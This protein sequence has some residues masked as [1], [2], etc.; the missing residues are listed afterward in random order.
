MSFY[1]NNTNP[2]RPGPA[3]PNAM[4][5]ICERALIQ[6]TKV[7]D[8][9]LSQI[10]ETG[11]VLEL[12][13]L[14][15]ADPALPLTYIS[16]ENTP[17]QTATVSNLVIDRIETA[18][19]Y[20]NISLDVT[21]PVTVTYRD[22]NNVLGQGTSTITVTKNVVMFVP[23]PSATPINVTAQG[24]FNSR[25][26]TYTAENTFTVTGCLQIVIKVV[27]V[28]DILVPSYGY[29][30]L[31]PCQEGSTTDVCPGVFDTPIYPTATNN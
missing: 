5:G 30:V 2:F 15:P 26:G 11:I 28:V 12:T 10:T 25:I 16:A 24:L 22:A 7:F 27:G 23:Q 19:N 29:P 3:G 20:A 6:T 31:P 9:C 4:N 14:T 21:V 13:D 1:I 17:G 8:A 18:P